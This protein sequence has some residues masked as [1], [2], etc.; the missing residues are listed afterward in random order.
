MRETYCLKPTQGVPRPCWWAMSIR[1]LWSSFRG[2]SARWSR[3][4]DSHRNPSRN[5][6]RAGGVEAGCGAGNSSGWSQKHRSGSS[7]LHRVCVPII[8]IIIIISWPAAAI[9]LR[10]M[11][12]AFSS[13]ER[14]EFSL[15]ADWLTG[16][17]A[18]SAASISSFVIIITQR[19]SIPIQSVCFVYY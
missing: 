18:L 14:R 10:K 16:T 17:S 8:I 2:T 19:R 9:H 15:S 6:S 4:P 5:A 12:C 3:P 13:E 1:S 11:M 7:I